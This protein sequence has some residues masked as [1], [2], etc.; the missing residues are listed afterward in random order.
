[1]NFR[2]ITL[3]I[4]TVFMLAVSAS[5]TNVAKG[6]TG[7]APSGNAAAALD[8]DTGTRWES[9]QGSDGLWFYVDL[10]EETTLD[11]V[12][13]I[14]EDAYAKHYK[15]HVANEVTEE[16]TTNLNDEDS[17][18]HFASGWTEKAEVEESL[19]SFPSIKDI[20]LSGSARYVAVELIERGTNYGFS[21]W[22][23]G[24]YDA[25][26]D[27]AV[28]TTINLSAT[29]TKGATG[30]TYTFALTTLDQY[31]YNYA[32]T[33]EEN[34]SKTFECDNA[35]ATF[36][37]V[38]MTVTK[39]GTYNVTVKIG[40]VV[41]N[42][43]Q[44]QVVAEGNNLALNKT[45]VSYT[46]GSN[47]PTNAVD[48]KDT[49]WE[50]PEP[51]DATNHEYDAEIVVD[52]GTVCAINVVHTWFEGATSA[53]YTVTFSTDD[54]TFSE[55]L[56]AFTVTNGAGMIN[57]HDWL[58]SNDAIQ[59]RYVKFHST[60]ASTQYGT[61]LRE[62]QVFTNS[63][64]TLSSI[65]LSVDKECYATGDFTFSLAG[66]DQFGGDYDLSSDEGSYTTTNGTMNGNVLTL[67]DAEQVEV[68]YTAGN[69][70]QSNTVTVTA[71][72]EKGSDYNLAFNRPVTYSEGPQTG[73][74]DPSKVNDGIDAAAS[75]IGFA[76]PDGT[77]DHTYDCW[78]AIELARTF[79]IDYVK[80]SWEGANSCQ[81][82]VEA[83]TDGVTYTTLG[84]YDKVA[85]L[86]ART[87]YFAGNGIEAKFI[88]IH[89]TKASTGYGTKLQEVW[90]YDVDGTS[91]VNTIAAASKVTVVGNSVVL[92]ED[93]ANAAVYSVNGAMVATA[94]G[95]TI[96]IANLQPGVYL[97][98][99]VMTDG[100]ATVTK[101][102]K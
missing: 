46:E 67:T 60:R 94:Q 65:V 44:I 36:N 52:L 57:R 9:A 43:V 34:A 64:T 96:D 75:L 79:K 10:G 17:S 74:S 68:Y 49:I 48:G 85:K 54:I 76:E 23:F 93:T 31:G 19:S 71:V 39:R 22:E 13:I 89:S 63:A 12:K 59:A 47:N 73:D 27:A 16:M 51:S 77:V 66:Y 28:L 38:T 70:V 40:D 3:L 69:G 82:T 84:S 8:G 25:P 5:A 102:V 83:S 99:A 4:A 56:E 92:P 11:H 87:D 95:S 53:D 50:T 101:I 91:G 6:K 62:L 81:Y 24:V 78:V 7:Y 100:T 29:T 88:K 21:F 61:K 90:V 98:K 2:K 55:P 32:L 80:T 15:I 45:I 18:K 26:E 14:W 1:M 20:S 97:V 42:T 37:D 58:V 33:A 72:S 35:A 30:D 41:S 86:E